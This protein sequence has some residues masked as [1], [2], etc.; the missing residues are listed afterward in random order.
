MAPLP[1]DLI[2]PACPTD[3]RSVGNQMRN[4]RSQS[5]ISRPQGGTLGSFFPCV[6]KKIDW[7]QSLLVI[8]NLNWSSLQSLSW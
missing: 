1:T 6:K 8:E 7:E 5:P 3:K 2:N 4:S